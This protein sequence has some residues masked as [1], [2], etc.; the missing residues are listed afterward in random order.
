MGKVGLAILFVFIVLALIN[1]SHD[2]AMNYTGGGVVQMSV[3]VGTTSCMVTVQQDDGTSH[4]YNK[5]VAPHCIG[6]H[7]GSRVHVTRGMVD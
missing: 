7:A 2:P 3:P 4:T 1:S 6:F 5:L